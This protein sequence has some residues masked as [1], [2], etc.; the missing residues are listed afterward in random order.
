[1]GKEQSCQRIVLS[2]LDIHIQKNV[3][4][5]TPY[6]TT[7]S[8]WTNGLNV[9]AGRRELQDGKERILWTRLGRITLLLLHILLA[10]K[11]AHGH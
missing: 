2:Q 9:R 10:V 11:I 7:N 6:T 5:L 8:K 3:S 1:M 4:H